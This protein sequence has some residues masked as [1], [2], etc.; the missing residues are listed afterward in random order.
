M[1]IQCKGM[2]VVLDIKK[3]N[4]LH[5][6]KCAAEN[7]AHISPQ[8]VNKKVNKSSAV[9]K[10]TVVAL[11]LGLLSCIAYPQ[12]GADLMKNEN[13]NHTR[14]EIP[15]NSGKPVVYQVFTRLFGNTN[16]TNKPWGTIE[17]NGVGKF[18]DF[19]PQALQSIKALGT[20]HIWYTGVP[21]HALATS[22]LNF[23]ITD[24]DPDVIK[25]RAGSPYAVK[26]YYNVNPDLADNPACLLYTSPSPRDS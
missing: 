11:S 10:L 22:Y 2:L 3:T 16:T 23:G 15:P 19:T 5:T 21:H 13:A 18:S 14:T 17:E 6:V 4:H 9:K 25:G 24:D 26:D 1:A 20:T 8:R 12:S 7:A